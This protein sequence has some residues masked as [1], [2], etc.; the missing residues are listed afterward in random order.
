M[1]IYGN[2]FVKKANPIQ[3]SLYNDIDSIALSLESVVYNEYLET[4]YF[5]ESCTDLE[6][7]KY[8]EEKSQILLEVSFKDIKDKVV[9]IFK[10]LVEKIK[11]LLQRIKELF[12]SKKKQKAKDQMDKVKR[13]N[14]TIDTFSTPRKITSNSNIYN[15]PDSTS[16]DQSK[17]PEKDIAKEAIFNQNIK[18]INKIMDNRFLYFDCSN[19]MDKDAQS[20]ISSL[21]NYVNDSISKLEDYLTFSD[22]E[23][24]QYYDMDPEK[25]KRYADRKL[26]KVKNMFPNN[27]MDFFIIKPEY[28]SNG[29][30]KL[31]FTYGK[32]DDR[33][34]VIHIYKLEET[35]DND[36]ND[37]LEKNRIKIENIK[38]FDQN[39]KKIE[40]FIAYQIAFDNYNYLS[41][42]SSNLSR[43][44][45]D[46]SKYIYKY[47]TQTEEKKGT[48][49][50]YMRSYPREGFEK[51]NKFLTG[52]IGILRTNISV[53]SILIKFESKRFSSACNAADVLASL[54]L[55]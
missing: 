8:L 41:N 53:I 29:K 38:D 33:E 30:S 17:E 52:L 13:E 31:I 12:N 54:V 49:E 26:D 32:N 16:N 44:I 46:I 42:I 51:L 23:K 37:I 4:S 48:D 50:N 20:N 45:N 18:I 19:Y 21:K 47:L 28:V 35:I 43:A 25:A 15:Q 22:P 7:R 36:L 39:Y 11:Q 14:V 24:V 55:K 27:Y 2:C 9:K 1:S 3:E 10:L 34:A 40:Q 6:E 5:I